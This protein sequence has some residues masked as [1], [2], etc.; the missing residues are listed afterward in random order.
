MKRFPKALRI[1]SAVIAG[2]FCLVCVGSF[3][4]CVHISVERPLGPLAVIGA[5]IIGIGACLLLAYYITAASERTSV[6]NERKINFVFTFPRKPSSGWSAADDALLARLVY[7][8]GLPDSEV[9]RIVKDGVR[10]AVY[11]YRE[12]HPVH[13][14]SDEEDF[15]NVFPYE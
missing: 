3:L 2:L 1:T 12:D 4:D 13:A 15:I 7:D 8:Y 6:K 11:Q 14:P 9:E 10:S 5:V